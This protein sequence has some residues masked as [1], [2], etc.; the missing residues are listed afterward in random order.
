VKYAW[1]AQNKAVWPVSMTCEVLWVSAS[2]YFERQRRRKPQPASSTPVDGRIS[3]RAL[4][5]HV[6]GLHAEVKGEDG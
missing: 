1:I 2:G 3:K 5:V 6:R 4:L